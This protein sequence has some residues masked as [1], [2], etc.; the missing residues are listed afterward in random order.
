MENETDA[1]L[2]FRILISVSRNVE[3]SWSVINAI[4]A[5]AN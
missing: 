5:Y 4:T 2:L 3:T 1:H